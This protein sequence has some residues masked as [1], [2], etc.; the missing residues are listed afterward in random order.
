MYTRFRE[1]YVYIALAVTAIL[2]SAGLA[3]YDRNSSGIVISDEATDSPT[4]SFEDL[5]G[6]NDPVHS[7]APYIDWA[8][9]ADACRTDPN[10]TEL[11][12]LLR[13]S[14]EAGLHKRL[15][16]W[17]SEEGARDLVARLGGLVAGAPEAYDSAANMCVARGAVAEALL[18]TGDA[19]NIRYVQ[20]VYA[21]ISSEIA[22][23]EANDLAAL[24]G[25]VD[26]PEEWALSCLK[27]KISAALYKHVK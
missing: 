12:L 23:A 8:S 7:L 14:A 16:Y 1:E 27:S 9:R 6:Y 26:R 11:E 19:E 15:P 2:G 22:D 10:E 21:E 17:L 18:L 13:F 20:E 25:G 3:G 4:R 5:M 24:P